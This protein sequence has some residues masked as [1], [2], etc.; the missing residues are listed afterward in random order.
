MNIHVTPTQISIDRAAIPESA[1]VAL[2]RAFTFVS[3]SELRRERRARARKWN[4]KAKPIHMFTENNGSI[5]L[6]SGFLEGALSVLRS[7]TRGDAVRVEW[8]DHY[9]RPYPPQGLVYAGPDP[10]DFQEQALDAIL[11]YRRG[12]IVAPTSAGKAIIAAIAIAEMAEPFLFFVPAVSLA[13]QMVERMSEYLPDVETSG[14]LDTFGTVMA[15]QTFN[16]LGTDSVPNKRILIC[17]ESHRVPA[18]TY[19]QATQAADCCDIRIG[20]TGTP[21]GRSD[22]LDYIQ[23]G[24]T[25]P[26]IYT[27]SIADA[28]RANLRCPVDVI[29]VDV[30]IPDSALSL[31][32][33]SQ[34]VLLETAAIVKN[35][36]AHQLAASLCN[37]T[38]ADEKI[39]VFVERKDHGCA[40]N[41]LIP[42]SVFFCSANAANAAARIERENIRVVIGT[43]CL[44]TGIDLPDFTIMLRLKGRRGAADMVQEMGRGVRA[45]ESGRA[46]RVY[47]FAYNGH[48]TL[49]RQS[50]SRRRI[51]RREA[52]S[53]ETVSAEELNAWTT[54]HPR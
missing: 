17:D 3:K 45:G 41:R 28:E 26:V 19:S 7:E 15:F 16:A 31:S 22:G 14:D 11:Q 32:G 34:Y 25:G 18:A 23:R 52:R 47:D 33:D 12:L 40:L 21:E 46:L 49:A 37:K 27:A 30:D 10:V 39:L 24:A 42:D 44:N 54:K 51:Y 8:S 6:P 20:F 35:E 4:Y 29:M 38:H 9:F 2:A 13:S 36:A 50:V 43:K 48:S 5:H 53:V 1:L